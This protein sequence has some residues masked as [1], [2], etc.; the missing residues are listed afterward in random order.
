[1]DYNEEYGWILTKEYYNKIMKYDSGYKY[2]DYIEGVGYVFS[3][4]DD[5]LRKAISGKT[6]ALRAGGD[7]GEDESEEGGFDF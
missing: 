7:I 2:T 3:Y 6:K 5:D 4:I 1:M